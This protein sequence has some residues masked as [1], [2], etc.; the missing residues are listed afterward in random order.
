MRNNNTGNN[1][2]RDDT[3]LVSVPDEP[4]QQ[5][6]KTDSTIRV[7]STTP[8]VEDR[9]K[10]K[11]NQE[12]VKV[13]EPKWTPVPRPIS[14]FR[15]SS[16]RRLPWKHIYTII[17][18]LALT[19]STVTTTVICESGILNIDENHGEAELCLYEK[20]RNIAAKTRY[21]ISLPPHP[22]MERHPV[23]YTES[24]NT[25]RIDCHGT[26]VCQHATWFSRYLIGNP[27]CSVIKAIIT[28]LAPIIL[29]LLIAGALFKFSTR[30]RRQPVRG[31][32]PSRLQTMILTLMVL[33]TVQGYECTDT[34]S[35][36][37]MDYVCTSNQ[38][39]TS[40]TRELLFNTAVRQACIETTHSGHKIRETQID[41]VKTKFI[42]HKKSMFF[43]RHTRID[44]PYQVSCPA[45]KRCGVFNG[46]AN[47]DN[48]SEESVFWDTDKY[49]GRSHCEEI[50]GGIL[51]GCF[52]TAPACLIFRPSFIPTDDAVYEVFTCS[53]WTPTIVVRIKEK[54]DGRV[55]NQTNVEITPYTKIE[56]NHL[57]IAVE[58][59]TYRATRKYL[60]E[61]FVTNSKLTALLSPTTS[62][63]IMC[64]SSDQAK[65]R[66]GSCNVTQPCSCA[67]SSV[68][69]KCS[70]PGINI[71]RTFYYN[72]LPIKSGNTE[73]D[74]R[75][76][77]VEIS[78][79]EEEVNVFITGKEM[80]DTMMLK[81]NNKC[82]ISEVKAIGCYD[83]EHGMAVQLKC[84][85]TEKMTIAVKCETQVTTIQCDSHSPKSKKIIYAREP[86]TRMECTAF[87][88]EKTKFWINASLIYMP[89]HVGQLTD[90]KPRKQKEQRWSLGTFDMEL[91]NFGPIFGSLW[92]H[93]RVTV[94]TVV[95]SILAIIIIIQLAPLLIIIIGNLLSY[96]I[97][98]LNP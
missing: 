95:V 46:C 2:P 22:H 3:P 52:F 23:M 94:I 25:R 6:K 73:I 42:C 84:K 39:N 75:D 47:M 59:I 14:P 55:V 76:T 61:R 5:R 88:E 20:C 26:D 44:M 41:L 78:S 63:N 27:H 79:N 90:A 33:N 17:S 37:Q 81:D 53:T 60:G 80:E 56:H 21:S 70:C 82:E 13:S 57:S 72:S 36:H 54:V 18:L 58:Q 91:P 92:N 19:V 68:P 71:E 9:Q 49:P 83:C 28:V 35:R 51:K 45:T 8:Q 29:V 62:F 64:E 10:G 43:T 7:D 30:E 50:P 85:S 98:V 1:S 24:G 38:C 77:T 74:H 67:A 86:E 93:W 40:F 48:I 12:P 31:Y 65:N 89:E 97:K 87:C 32:I 4:V 11:G 34:L 15:P 96:L 69:P 16:R 66:F